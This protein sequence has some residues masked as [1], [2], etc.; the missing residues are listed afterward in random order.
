MNRSSIIRI[1][2]GTIAIIVALILATWALGGFTD[3]SVAGGIALILGI[4]ISMALGIGLMA[5][6]FY[7]SRS[8][9]DEAVHLAAS[10]RETAGS[11]PVPPDPGARR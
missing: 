7:S 2:A 5:L 6:V 4:A 9:R 11:K 3:L 1:V 10:E 8:E